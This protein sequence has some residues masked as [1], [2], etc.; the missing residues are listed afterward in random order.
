MFGKSCLMQEIM[1]KTEFT[2]A[3]S[4]TLLKNCNHVPFLITSFYLFLKIFT[5]VNGIGNNSKYKIRK[6]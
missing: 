1:T 4:L 3:F 5:K 6:G 2:K